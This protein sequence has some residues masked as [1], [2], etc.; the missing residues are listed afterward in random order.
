MHAGCQEL[1]KHEIPA[2]SA[3]LDLYKL[4]Q[5]IGLEKLEGFGEEVLARK[6]NERIN[7]RYFPWSTNEFADFRAEQMTFR[8]YRPDFA[9]IPFSD[10]LANSSLFLPR[11]PNYIGTPICRCG[12]PCSLRPDA[13]GKVKARIA[14]ASSSSEQGGI[15]GEKEELIFFWTCNAGGQAQGKTCGHFQVMD[16][17]KEGRGKYFVQ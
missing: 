1:F 14:S 8:F 9:P 3:G 5:S 6:W 2:S 7:V 15:A 4:P 12:I 17:K 11:D 13:R 10:A 16:F